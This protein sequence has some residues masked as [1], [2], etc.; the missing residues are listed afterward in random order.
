M[1]RRCGRQN[2][3]CEWVL[4]VSLR[5]QKRVCDAVLR[6]YRELM[7]NVGREE[8]VAVPKETEV[9]DG[10]IEKE[11]ESGLEVARN[12]CLGFILGGSCPVR[13]DAP[14]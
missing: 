5:G 6:G 12:S 9:R 7:R 13:D 4:T 2:E 11:N 10:E 3:A 1:R 14:D 8:E